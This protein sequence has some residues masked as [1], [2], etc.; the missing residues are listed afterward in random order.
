[1]S[2]IIW[3]DLWITLYIIIAS[4]LDSGSL[5]SYAQNKRSIVCILKQIRIGTDNRADGNASGNKVLSASV[6]PQRR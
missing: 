1:M 5:D 6:S 4:W 2:K 3:S